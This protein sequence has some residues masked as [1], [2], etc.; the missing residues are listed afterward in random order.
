[1]SPEWTYIRWRPLR[2][3]PT[4]DEASLP[5]ACGSQGGST[6]PEHAGRDPLGIFATAIRIAPG[7]VASGRFRLPMTHGNPSVGGWQDSCVVPWE[8]W[9]LC[10]V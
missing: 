5:P 6:P 10:G 7:V 4:V 1:M 2:G 9:R 3:A 8:G